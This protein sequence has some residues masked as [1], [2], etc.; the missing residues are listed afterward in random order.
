MGMYALIED[1]FYRWLEELKAKG[2]AE[3]EAYEILREED[4][5]KSYND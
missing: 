4:E 5:R 3:D 2:I 1:D